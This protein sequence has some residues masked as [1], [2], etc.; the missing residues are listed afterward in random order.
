MKILSKRFEILMIAFT[1]IVFLSFVNVPGRVEGKYFPVITDL[2]YRIVSVEDSLTNIYLDFEKLRSECV[3]RSIEFYLYEMIDGE[4][5]PTIKLDA[6]FIGKEQGRLSG[7]HK[8]A[9]PWAVRATVNQ[10]QNVS[11]II[12][13]RCHGLGFQTITRYRVIDGEAERF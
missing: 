2:N 7:F 12:R 1:W 13:H 11:V 8:G 3:F 9:G 6:E 4:M 10:M 5:K